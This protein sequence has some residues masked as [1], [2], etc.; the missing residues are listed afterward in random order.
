MRM[1]VD[2]GRT[3]ECDDVVVAR[4]RGSLDGSC[5]HCGVLVWLP[6]RRWHV[7]LDGVAL[8]QAW[9]EWT[10]ASYALVSRWCGVEDVHGALLWNGAS[11]EV[12]GQQRR[13]AV[14]TSA[15]IRSAV[16]EGGGVQCFFLWWGG[17]LGRSLGGG[18]RGL[19]RC[20]K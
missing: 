20:K 10:E 17:A 13:L 8:V 4:L 11:V 6:W 12:A 18:S 1:L 16:R 15:D 5:R 19:L 14:W 2:I 3:H 7:V 9:T